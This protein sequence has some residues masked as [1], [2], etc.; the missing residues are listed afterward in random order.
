MS[1]HVLAFLNNSNHIG[2]SSSGMSQSDMSFMEEILS[3]ND[4]KALY[5]GMESIVE[6]LLDNNI[7]FSH[8]GN[9]DLMDKDGVVIASAGMLLEE[10]KIA[11]DPVDEYSKKI[12]ERAGYKVVSSDEFKLDLLNR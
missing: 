11:I 1:P 12:F 6:Q 4:I 8:E 3:K 5:P 2:E 10:Y 7:P 9:V